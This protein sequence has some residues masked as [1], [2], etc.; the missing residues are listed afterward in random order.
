MPLN[1][2]ATR[3]PRLSMSHFPRATPTL[4][5]SL[6]LS[7]DFPELHRESFAANGSRNRGRSGDMNVGRGGFQLARNGN[8]RQ[9]NSLQDAAR[10]A[11]FCRRMQNNRT[12]RLQKSSGTDVT[13]STPRC[14]ETLPT[15]CEIFRPQG[16]I[17]S[18]GD[19]NL[20]AKP[21]I[22]LESI[23]LQ[24]KPRQSIEIAG[25]YLSTW[26]RG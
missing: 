3:M 14:R 21:L 10:E 25:V 23:Q 26:L 24:N 8:F 7:D 13:K 19:L 20:Q 18:Q 2:C 1:F 12:R 22:L 16:V 15:A 9:H 11:S 5:I 6:A 17:W 4:R